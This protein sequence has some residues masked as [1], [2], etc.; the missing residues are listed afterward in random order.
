MLGKILF[1]IFINDLH[2]GAECILS[3]FADDTKL[4]G[5]ADTPE[6]AA[7]IQRD[8]DRLEKTADRNLTRFNRGKCTVLHLGKN[9][10]STYISWGLTSW[11]AAL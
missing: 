1:N 8:L 7:A 10:R 2:D 3:K 11:K 6:G 5:A 4:G 9:N